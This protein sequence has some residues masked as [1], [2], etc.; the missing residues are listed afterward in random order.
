MLRWNWPESVKIEEMESAEGRLV[1]ELVT[2][3]EQEEREVCFLQTCALG[4]CIAVETW[5]PV[6]G[7]SL[8]GCDQN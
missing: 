8:D 4:T 3:C 6:L 5:V 1:V 7:E 2:E